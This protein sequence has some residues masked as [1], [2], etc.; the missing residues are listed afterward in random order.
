MNWRLNANISLCEE[1]NDNSQG[2]VCSPGTKEMKSVLH[3]DRK[4]IKVPS[5]LTS[6]AQHKLLL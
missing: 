6:E 2:I 3:L 1:S 4:D 5:T